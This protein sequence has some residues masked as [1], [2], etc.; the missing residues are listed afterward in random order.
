[1]RTKGFTLI[2]LLVVIA[3]IAILAALLLP[4]LNSA[5]SRATLISCM[6]NARGLVQAIN[7]YVA[8]HD[9]ILPPGKYG[10]QSGYPVMKCWMNLL[11]E[12]GYVDDK[13]GFQCPADDVTDNEAD[14]YDYG[15]AW[16]YWWASYALSQHVN[17]LFWYD[18][19]AP[20]QVH[21]AA[22]ARLSAHRGF[23]DK[24]ILLGE[25]ERNFLEGSWF[26][27]GDD[28]S[29]KMVYEHQFPISRHNGKCSYVML[30]GHAKTM[31]V[32]SSNEA[33]ASEFRDDIESQLRNC[34]A[35]Y[36]GAFPDGQQL[37]H[38]CFWLSHK[39][40][41]RVAPPAW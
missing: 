23:D 32:P 33:D 36:F 21:E 25:S 28:E 38:V 3:V 7:G 27:W 14:Y 2:E 41:L 40:G 16:P 8:V 9:G 11:Y 12:G 6:S 29:Y 34:D 10:H 24:Q 39:V 22:S 18:A 30:D 13:K 31:L 15:P 5:R 19:N 4:A 26:G 37:V 20:E 17:D 1:M 35:E